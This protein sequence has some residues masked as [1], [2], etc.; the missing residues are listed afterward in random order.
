M[1]SLKLGLLTG[2]CGWRTGRICGVSGVS[3]G[4]GVGAGNKLVVSVKV[5]TRI[6]AEI[7]IALEGDYNLC[8]GIS[9]DFEHVE[10]SRQIQGLSGTEVIIGSLSPVVGG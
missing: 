2:R 1:V 3:C 10:P 4:Q 5:G 8:V 6:G 9:C 7:R